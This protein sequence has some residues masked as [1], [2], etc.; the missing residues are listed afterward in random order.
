MSDLAIDHA[1][2]ALVIIDL[3]KGIVAGKTVPHASADVVSRAVRLSAACHAKGIPVML[4]RVDPGP[5]GM[6]FPKPIADQPRPATTFGA[7]FADIVPD[8]TAELADAIITK[9]QPNA[10]FGTD[11]EIQLRRRGIRTI[12]LAG[13][14]T[15]LGVEATARAAHERGFEQVFVED[16][17]AAREL[18]LHV[19]SVT[20]IFPTIG[21]VR[22]LD[23]V[24]S[25]L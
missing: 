22:S 21:R 3:Q 4:V 25:S 6:L 18:D 15:N 13:I 24:V 20:R 12:I 7:D 16:V 17:M 11:L 14:A 23:Q 2:S 8:L 1:T 10:F 5:D 19:H 9:H